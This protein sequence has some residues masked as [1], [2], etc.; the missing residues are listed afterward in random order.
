MHPV[1]SGLQENDLL[2][3][4]YRTSSG[5]ARALKVRSGT[6]LL[7][8][9]T[10]V[11]RLGVCCEQQHLYGVRSLRRPH[12]FAAPVSAASARSM[13]G[14]RSAGTARDDEENRGD[15]GGR[16]WIRTSDFLHVKQAL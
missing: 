10:S 8:S 4:V 12:P 3:L 15:D 14:Q 16:Y 6:L 9:E 13:I 5:L 2:S 7:S 11:P 1:P